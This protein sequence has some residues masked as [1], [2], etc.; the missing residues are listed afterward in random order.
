MKKKIKLFSLLILAVIFMPKGVFAKDIVIDFSKIYNNRNSEVTNMTQR[1]EDALDYLCSDTQNGNL[2]YL[3]SHSENGETQYVDEDGKPLIIEDNDKMISLGPDVTEED[4]IEVDIVLSEDHDAYVSLEG[5]DKIIVKF[6]EPIEVPD[7]I[8]YD[9]EKASDFYDLSNFQIHLFIDRLMRNA[10]DYMIFLYDYTNKDFYSITEKLLFH[11]EDDSDLY[12]K[13]T[14]ANN[15]TEDDNIIFIPLEDEF[16]DL[17]NYANGALSKYGIT[18]IQ[19]HFSDKPGTGVNP[20]TSSGNT[21]TNTQV[22]KVP[23]TAEKIPSILYI[24]S[25]LLVI[26][27]TATIYHTIKKES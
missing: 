23:N 20:I 25:A 9:F 13:I 27:G 18:G 10:E 5:Y 1:Q 26:I 4:N 2:K 6:G 15:L 7:L 14:L 12:Y 22:L 3:C 17:D 24:G 11:L 8:T 19:F 16:N 21:N